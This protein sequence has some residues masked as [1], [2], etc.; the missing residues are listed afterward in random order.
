MSHFDDILG[1]FHCLWLRCSIAIMLSGM[2]EILP[3]QHTIFLLQL[4][5]SN[6]NLGPLC[7]CSSITHHTNPCSQFLHV[8]PACHKHPWLLHYCTYS[9]T[10]IAVNINTLILTGPAYHSLFDLLSSHCF[11]EGACR[12]VRSGNEVWR[13]LS[14]S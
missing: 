4:W 1:G 7:P 2:V 3:P 12:H 8:Q 14:A 11:S 13:D 6:G 10:L 9:S 5:Q